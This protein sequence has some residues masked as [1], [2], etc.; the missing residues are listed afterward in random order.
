MG[1]VRRNTVLTRSARRTQRI[2]ST[3]WL[4]SAL[5]ASSASS[6]SKFRFRRMINRVSASGT[7]CWPAERAGSRAHLLRRLEVK[8]LH[9]LRHA[10]PALRVW[11]RGG[12]RFHSDARADEIAVTVDVVD[13]ADGGPEFAGAGV[14]VGEG[15][16]FALDQGALITSMPLSLKCG[17]AASRWRSWL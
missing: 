8:S 17:A 6:A 10:I 4:S 5:S 9:H 7:F 12:V 13:A 14:F 16:G 15:G 11:R 3:A 1:N 2:H